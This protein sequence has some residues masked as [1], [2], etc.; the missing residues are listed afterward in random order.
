MKLAITAHGEY[1]GSKFCK[2]FEEC[3]YLIIY[4]TQTKTYGSRKSPSFYSKDP[5]DLI[6]FLK[7]VHI[8]NIITGKEIKNGFLKIFIPKKEIQTVE[9][10]IGEFLSTQPK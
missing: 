1:I 10:A 7:A 4:D 2:N 6:N 9:E 3:E 8:K 5:N